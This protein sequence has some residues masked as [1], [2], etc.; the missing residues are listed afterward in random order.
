[1]PITIHQFPCLQDNYGF[2]VRDQASGLVATIDTPDADA[3]TAAAQAQGWGI[4]LVLN[5]HWHPD[6]AGGNALI[7]ERFGAQVIAPEEVR[8]HFPVDRIVADGDTVE[9]GETR[10]EVLDTGGHT[11]GHVCYHAPGDATIFVG[12]T[13]FPLGCGRLFEGTPKQMFDSLTR[14]AALPDQIAVYCAHEYTE[15]NLR[16]A[17]TIEPGNRQLRQRADEV[18][19]ARVKGLA[20]V[21]STLALEKATNPF[22]RCSR[23]RWWLRSRVP[24]HRVLIG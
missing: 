6:H 14:L 21:P 7:K 15:L 2:L 18:G 24:T 13:L 19:I 16:F 12:D 23:R 11:T 4:D 8:A 5:T 20:T 9:L 3:I 17:L 22:L 1:M 10:F